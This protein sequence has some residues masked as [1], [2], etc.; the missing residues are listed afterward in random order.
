[1]LPAIFRNEDDRISSRY[2][3]GEVSWRH[4]SVGVHA[5]DRREA[6]LRVQFVSCDDIR[7]EIV[8][9]VLA[10]NVGATDNTLVESEDA[11]CDGSA[12]LLGRS[13]PQTNII[14]IELEPGLNDS[15]VSDGLSACTT[16]RRE[17]HV[18][19]RLQVQLLLAG[20]RLLLPIFTHTGG[21]FQPW[22]L[23]SGWRVG[24]PLLDFL[25]Q[26]SRDLLTGS[27]DILRRLWR[28]SRG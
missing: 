18:W 23:A 12:I 25:L 17:K 22:L 26:N 21:I 1:L 13:I 7:I 15:P 8:R 19:Q 11:L 9:L 27:I 28:G 5:A 20:T 3:L 6:G 16:S 4:Y 24:L 2:L 10:E 14:G